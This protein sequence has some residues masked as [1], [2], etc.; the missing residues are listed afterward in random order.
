[1]YNNNKQG[2]FG[3]NQSSS[4][5]QVLDTQTYELSSLINRKQLKVNNLELQKK[6][7]FM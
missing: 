6:I 4:Q 7:V 2:L 1:M 3:Q 5:K